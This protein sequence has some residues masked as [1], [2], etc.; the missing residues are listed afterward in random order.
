MSRRVYL[1]VLGLGSKV[2]KEPDESYSYDK[3]QYT[4]DNAVST[5]TRYVQS[6][7]VELSKAKPFDAIYL[8]GTDKAHLWHYEAVAREI[9]QHGG[10]VPEKI[11]ISD[12]SASGDIWQW[13]YEI[14]GCITDGDELFFDLTHGWRMQSLVFSA[15][16]NFVRRVRKVSLT[17]VY[18][19]MYEKDKSPTPIVNLADF[20]AINDWADGIGRVVDMADTRKLAEMVSEAP[21]H[22]FGNLADDRLVEAL[23]RLGRCLTNINVNEVATV[24]D[25]ALAVV[26]QKMEDATQA[27]RLLLESVIKAFGELGGK[28]GERCYDA[29]Y[30]ELQR[31]IIKLLVQYG[32]YMQACTVMRECIGSLGMTWRGGKYCG[33]DRTKRLYA[34]TLCRMLGYDQ[35]SWKFE[36]VEFE[37]QQNLLSLKEEH[38][39]E[40][41]R[42]SVLYRELA[43]IRNGFDHAWTSTS[44]PVNITEQALSI[45]AQFEN[46][47]P[48]IAA[49]VC[50][51]K[52]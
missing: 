30:Y 38:E 27:E 18:Y 50:D 19:G 29:T 4:L 39:F 24:A 43:K 21:E 45:H 23:E 17:A 34:N 48:A 2:G 42:L 12:N 40:W 5:N 52:S 32:Y 35:E 28:R 49:R 10:P 47:I 8:V 11:I 15:G 31:S 44:M 13:L 3:S 14:L 51:H 46:V 20:Y 41:T 22:Q 26:K 6:A 37:A 25:E 7:V 1:A 33:K 9:V 36:G 16:I